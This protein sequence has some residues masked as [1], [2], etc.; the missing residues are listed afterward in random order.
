VVVLLGKA[1]SLGTIVPEPR[2]YQRL[3]K[4]LRDDLNF[5]STRFLCSLH[6]ATV[7]D[8]RSWVARNIVGVV[9]SAAALKTPV[10]RCE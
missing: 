7:D 10:Q 1:D 2:L 9:R 5:L 8:Y 4:R 6:L 3:P